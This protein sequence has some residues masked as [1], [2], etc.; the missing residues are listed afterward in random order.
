MTSV[1][2][3]IQ[4]ESDNA[5]KIGYSTEVGKRYLNI[6]S[7][8]R[9]KK[10]GEVKILGVVNAPNG[11]NDEARLHKKFSQYRIYSQYW[12]AEWFRPASAV[13][14]FI[15]DNTH[16]PSVEDDYKTYEDTLGKRYNSSLQE[17]QVKELRAIKATGGSVMSWARENRVAYPT[18]RKAANGETYRWM[19]A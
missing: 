7:E 16:M 14:Q 6:R 8:M 17:S 1:V 9:K 12:L 11:K 18:A 13:Q 2:Y 4:R 15:A 10:L 3:F 5:I 19:T